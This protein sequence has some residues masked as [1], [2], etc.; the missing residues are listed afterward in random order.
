MATIA[1][2]NVT[3]AEI[4]IPRLGDWWADVSTDSGDRIPDGTR[5]EI[6]AETLRLSGA[7]VRGGISGDV[8]RYQVAGRPE[9]A[10]EVAPRAYRSDATVKLSTVVEGLSRDV[11]GASFASLI[12]KPA[13]KNLG[14]HYEREGSDPARGV[15]VRARDII[16]MLG[17]P[18]YVRADGVTVFADRPSG[19]I[20]TDQEILVENRNLTLGLRVVNTEDPGAFV[21]GLIFEGEIISEVIVRISHEDIVLDVWAEPGWFA[22]AVQ[23][24]MRRIAPD[25]WYRGVFAYQVVG[26][27]QPI[28]VD[29]EPQWWRHD[30]RPVNAKWLPE[31]GSANLW[32]GCAGHSASLSA[33]DTVL[34][35]FVDADASRPA[36]V[37]FEPSRGN[38]GPG[39]PLVSMHCAGTFATRGTT[40]DSRSHTFDVQTDDASIVATGTAAVDGAA[41]DCG[42][43]ESPV[44]RDG[45][46]AAFFT[47]PSSTTPSL[48]PYG[49]LRLAQTNPSPPPVVIPAANS[50]SPVVPTTTRVRA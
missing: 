35:A 11:L 32:P 34:V 29:D 49:Y 38:H 37:G 42:G 41:V 21:P 50:V 43:A 48:V 2:Q 36:V 28:L 31:I 45:D 14:R 47:D 25:L 16:A 5:V 23:A 20:V 44:F 3:R 13:E 8:G 46:F 18:W 17:L 7:I 1:G 12:V 4:R 15:V 19:P 9:W 39:K 33:G 40:F 30:L 10:K 26:P 24:I 27:S 22:K 6:V